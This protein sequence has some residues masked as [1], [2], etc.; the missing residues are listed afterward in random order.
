[1]VGLEG[2]PKKAGQMGLLEGWSE[3]DALGVQKRAGQMVP[4]RADLRVP[5]E[6][7]SEGDA[8]GVLLEGWSDG[9]LEGWSEGL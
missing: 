8:L 9:A 7:W 5:L 2:R 4:W 3:G 6:G 1:M